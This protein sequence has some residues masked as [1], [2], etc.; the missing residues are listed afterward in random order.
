MTDELHNVTGPTTTVTND[1]YREYLRLRHSKPRRWPWVAGI[2]VAL[3]SGVGIGSAGG[4]EDVAKM[5]GP[6]PTVTVTA[7]PVV[8]TET[9]TEVPDACLEALEHGEI[10]FAFAADFAQ[11]SSDGFYAAANLDVAGIEAAADRME[12]INE[13]LS[14]VADDW[15]AAKAECR[16]IAEGG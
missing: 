4:G 3:L 16:R 1:E 14:P 12:R 5:S 2:V 7:E 8:E 13:Q 6:Q 11:A 9:V 10:G 15:N